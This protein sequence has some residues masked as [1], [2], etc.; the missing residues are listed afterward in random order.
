M[1]INLCIFQRDKNAE[2]KFASKAFGLAQFTLYTLGV[3]A[4]LV[5]NLQLKTSLRSSPRRETI[6]LT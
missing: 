6:K 3:I 2:N 1:K 4:I 5:I